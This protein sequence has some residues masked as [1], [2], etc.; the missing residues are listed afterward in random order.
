MKK[1]SLFI[2][3]LFAI[4]VFIDTKFEFIESLEISVG[5]KNGIRFAGVFLGFVLNYVFSNTSS[6]TK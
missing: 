1:S 6:E 3:I 5:W 2:L 4:C